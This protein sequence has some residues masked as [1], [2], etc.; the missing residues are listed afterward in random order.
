MSAR[1]ATSLLTR[2]SAKYRAPV[3]LS[4]DAE[5]EAFRAE[6]SAW[7][8]AHA[9]SPQT[10]AERKRSSGHLPG[11][12]RDWQLRLFDAGWLVPGW[13]P[14]LGGRDATPA[15]T[16][17]YFEELSRRGLPRALNPQGI[18]VVAPTLL[19]HGTPDQRARWLVPTLRGE[20]TWCLG[21]SEPDAGS[22][23]AAL[24]TSAELLA[25]GWHVN[26]QKVWTSGAQH[27]DWCLAYVRTEPEAPKHKGISVLVVDLGA[28]GLRIRPLPELTDPE[29]ADFNEVFFDDVVV[30]ADNLLGGRGDGWRISMGSLGHERGMLWVGQQ[31]ALERDVLALV[32]LG[33]ERPALGADARFRDD[34]G[35]SFVDALAMKVLGYAG[36]AKFARGDDAPEHTILKLFG[37]EAGQR[38]ADA[39]AQWQ[40]PAA[41]DADITSPLGQVLPGSWEE[42]WLHSFAHT[43]AGGSSEIQRNIISERLLGLPRR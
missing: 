1:P 19:E 9:P 30:A 29:H 31:N 3:R 12:A 6:L 20:V 41:F 14:E 21:M 13:P 17:A 5:T 28:P 42:G 40:G 2:A 37:S 25:D 26:G 32:A 18:G 39:A 34:V 10:I 35:A 4:S 7:L 22:D 15:Q 16:L 33:R 43:I 11:W 8:D 24:R 38:L 36:F 23:L 27:A